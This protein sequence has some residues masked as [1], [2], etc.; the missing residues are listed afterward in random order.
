MS[1]TAT[2]EPMFW[3]LPVQAGNSLIFGPREAQLFMMTQWAGVKDS[4]F[5]AAAKSVLNAL[6]GRASPDHARELFAK[7]IK[8]A[9]L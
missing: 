1:R 4:D 8:S 2:N 7:A 9:R 5:A 6:H 3:D